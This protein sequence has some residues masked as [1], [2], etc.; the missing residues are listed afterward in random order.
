[1]KRY[2]LSVLVLAFLSVVLSGCGE[3]VSG[4]GKDANRI[5]KGVQTIFVRDGN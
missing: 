3:T 5:G 1:M 4:I 2:V